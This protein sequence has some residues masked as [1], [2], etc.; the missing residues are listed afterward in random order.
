MP[1]QNLVGEPLARPETG[2]KHKP[3]M[4][5]ITVALLVLVNVIWAGSTVATKTALV[6]VPPMLLAFTRFSISGLLLY[7]VA[8]WRGIDM[9]VERRDWLAFWAFGTFG[10]CITYLF[11]YA[12]IH[13][14][15]ATVSSLLIASEPVFLT[16][17]SYLVLHE[18][19]TQMRVVG[20]LIGLVGVYLIVENGWTIH[21]LN[22]GG[23]GDMLIATGLL[24]ESASVVVGK[25]LVSKYSP[26][27]VVTYQMTIGA[28]ALAP[29]AAYDFF[30]VVHHGHPFHLSAAAVWS[31]L[32]LIL[33]CTVFG[34]MVW[35]T[36]LESR[37]PGEMSP[38]VFIQPIVGVLLGHLIRH[39]VITIPIAAGGCLIVGGIVI[40]TVA[41]RYGN[42]KPFAPDIVS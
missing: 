9:R 34:Y 5:M 6:D 24:F 40:I 11:V 36:L 4:P 10:L 30:H 22:G 35:F 18:Q 14:T 37:G 33:P 29:F 38:F 23:V 20:V 3:P 12:G 15:S 31:V 39:D 1:S 27:S 8:L 42:A 32:Y 28:I 2:P 25:R 26:V 21:D 41:S 19:I 16:V 13:R 17:L 7:S